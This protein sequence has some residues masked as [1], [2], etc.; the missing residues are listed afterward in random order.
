MTGIGEATE[1]RGP[2]R[3]TVTAR[4]VN[5]RYLDCAVRLRAPYRLLETELRAVVAAEIRRGRVELKVEIETIPD[6]PTAELC[7][8]TA[9]ALQRTARRWRRRGL[10]A[11]DLSAGELMSAV[12][13][14]RPEAG[15]P[16]MGA[17]ERAL[18]VRV[19]QRAVAAL[20]AEREREG[21]VLEDALRGHLSDLRREVEALAARRR[22]VVDGAPDEL[23]RRVRE[24]LEG[25]E[26]GGASGTGLA[27][28]RLVQEVALLIERGDTAEE[29][30]RL[31]GHLDG[32]ET[33]MAEEG[34]V[35]RRLDFL[36]QEILRELNTVGSKCRDLTMQ[37]A[38]VEGKVLCEQL[39]EQVQN[40]E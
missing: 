1:Q 2:S 27:P 18:A 12:R 23:E 14:S 11:S 34:A 22:E 10:V 20:V 15:S 36:T 30:E 25:H 39:R 38:V 19:S 37:R 7:D 21:Q 26:P 13:G 29:L 8:E 17:E 16:A 24:L 33:A 31:G 6:A 35:G 3:V 40:I 9:D 5:H 4:S 28:A 32:F